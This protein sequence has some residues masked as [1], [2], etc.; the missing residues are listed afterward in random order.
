MNANRQAPPGAILGALL[1]VIG[2]FILATRYVD[3]LSGAATWPPGG[4]WCERFEPTPR[5]GSHGASRTSCAS[6]TTRKPAR[7]R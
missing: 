3:A 2:L 1:I 4:A 7:S 5:A 6:R